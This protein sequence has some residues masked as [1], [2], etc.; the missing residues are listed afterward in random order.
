MQ[1]SIFSYDGNSTINDGTNFRAT[2]PPGAVLTQ[3]SGVPG[4][5]ERPH[6]APVYNYKARSPRY[7]PIQFVIL[8]AV[9]TGMDTLRRIFNT[10]D[11]N[12]LK[13]LIV[14][15]TANSDKQWYVYC[16][17]VS[18]ADYDGS[19][20]T[21]N[22]FV[23][24]PIWT[25]INANTVTWNITTSSDTKNV[26][27]VGTFPVDLQIDIK[28]TETKTGGQPYKRFVT[29][30]NTTLRQF[31]NYPVDLT[32]GGLN[33]A[34]LVGDTSVSNQ[35][36]NV[37]GI[38]TTATTIDIDT[39]VGGG[40]ASA[41]MGY[42]DTEQL[43]WTAN[44][45]TQLTGVVRGVNGTTA[46][47]HLDNA[48]IKRS[49]M[50]ADGDDIRVYFNNVEVNRWLGGMNSSSTKI[51]V[52]QTWNPQIQFDLGTALSAGV[53]TVIVINNTQSNQ[54]N[55]KVLP[56]KGAVVID[57]EIF[58][59]TGKDI[60][61]MQL[62]GVS[63]AARGTSAATH[64]AGAVIK[65]IEYDIKIAYGDRTLGALPFD[66]APKPIFHLT[67]SSNTSWVYTGANFSSTTSSW[68]AGA[69]THNHIYSLAQPAVR[70][71]EPYTATQHTFAEPSTTIGLSSGAWLYGTTA[72]GD[73]YIASWQIYHPAGIT[74]V[75]AD[76]KKFRTTALS[77]SATMKA[78]LQYGNFT[79]TVG[80]WTT[81]WN[82]SA[83]AAATWTAFTGSP[84]SLGA[85][86]NTIRLYMDMSTPAIANWEADI[87][88]STVS[89]TLDSGQTPTVTISAE[90]DAYE[91][92]VKI[93]DNSSGRYILVKDTVKLNQTLR[94]DGINHRVYLTDD[95][96]NR[97]PAL[98]LSTVRADWLPISPN[99][100]TTLAFL[101]T[102]TTGMTITITY[103]DRNH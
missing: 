97:F 78:A 19:S 14:K 12:G 98:S 71:S 82:Q 99:T 26:V 79:G 61:G 16:T 41:G 35:I 63:R 8:G 47:S 7:L 40:L 59:Y 103:N 27:T 36:N 42:V 74:A 76:G 2:F 18:M 94:V 57:S 34:N 84:T 80:T 73:R 55:I 54:I 66:N 4:F 81:L 37:A 11:D 91:L 46:T 3:A 69:W 52:T 86:Y 85:T 90:N 49:K 53:E 29:V 96:S 30:T 22:F 72:K 17:P 44:S 60:V 95:N 87:E 39:P 32:N 100:T 25:S 62:T 83:P 101:D 48:V 45:G 24:D 1:L 23:P 43:T 9:H 58:T 50:Q 56:A 15:D 93:T 33:T 6:F 64:S 67:N 65:W 28:P 5:V 68:R 51:W 75:V 38:T 92:N 13:Q 20:V 21:I 70:Q 31:F 10:F 89:L 88:L 77:W 102:G